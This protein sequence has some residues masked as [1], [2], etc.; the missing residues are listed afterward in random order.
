MSAHAKLSASKT[1]EWM[2]CPGQIVVDEM[3]PQPDVPGQAARL[4]T[5]AHH[6]IERCLQNGEMPDTY[7]GRLIQII[8]EGEED[9]GYSI[10]RKG[11]KLSRI[12]ADKEEL[13]FEIDEDMI[14][15]VMCMIT[16]V[17]N[18]C[19]E[20][21]LAPENGSMK[22]KVA[23]VAELVKKGTVRLETRTNLFPFR[24]DTGG[25]ADVTID[26]WPDV[27]EI[28]DYKHGSGIFVSVKGNPQLRTYGMGVAQET[29]GE[30]FITQSAM[31]DYDLVRMTVVQPRH[32][33]SPADGV[34]FEDMAL[35]E[36]VSWRDDV[37]MPAVAKV[38]EARE[39]VKK[40]WE[41]KSLEPGH[42]LWKQDVLD[43]LARDGY[44][45]MNNLEHK[46]W[47]CANE[48]DYPYAH[49]KVQELARIEFADEPVDISVD[50]DMDDVSDRLAWV[51]FLETWIKNMQ[52]KAK[53]VAMEGKPVRDHKL[54][55]K[56]K[57][58]AWRDEESDTEAIILALTKDFE[59]DKS[60]VVKAKVVTP[61]QAIDLAK[62]SGADKEL[63]DKFAED[64]THRPLGEID[65][66]H[67][68]K[69]GTPYVPDTA[70]ADFEAADA[71]DDE[72]AWA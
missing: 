22:R 19:V 46:C 54:I 57:H 18:R 25:T 2:H 56:N 59:V 28:V 40:R 61:T 34:M 49:E 27:L 36:L 35:S 50:E 14:E 10:L 30:E 38:D 65:L 63:V 11:A 20:L 29:M 13:T 33:D 3:F 53:A 71:E 68:S 48:T 37:L 39:F 62:K 41:L 23:N 69:K 16:Y 72:D 64:F 8:H 42:D 9:E 17:A 52:A 12:P 70:K 26:A 1:K 51:P 7:E 31:P 44:L 58:L 4:G 24:D 47:F 21:G 60:K 67:E 6:L 66:V 55:R 45:C 5:C 15:A 43:A 32:H